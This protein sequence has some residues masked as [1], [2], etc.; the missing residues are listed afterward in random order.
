MQKILRP[1]L[2]L[3]FLT[4]TWVI[5]GIIMLGLPAVIEAQI[6]ATASVPNVIGLSRAKAESEIMEAGLVTGTM[7]QASSAT[8]PTGNI[9]GQSPTTG[10][11]VIPGTAIN[12]VISVGPATFNVPNVMG[13]SQANAQT[14]ITAAGLIVGTVIQ[15]SSST[16]SAGSVISQNPKA[17]VAAS[18][19]SAV[20]LIVSSGP[21]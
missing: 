14:E 9:I 10:T 6:A 11:S 19:G 13:L 20:E 1:W 21:P 3:Y 7:A 15:T 16:I 12:L 5:L 17:G 8:V 4:F 2:A 18:Q